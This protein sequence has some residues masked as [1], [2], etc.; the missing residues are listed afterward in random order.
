LKGGKDSGGKNTWSRVLKERKGLL[1]G[2]AHTTKP[3]KGGGSSSGEGS[4][5][6]S[7]KGLRAQAN[8]CAV[9]AEEKGNLGGGKGAGDHYYQF[10]KETGK[11]STEHE[12]RG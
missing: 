3:P 7:K 4:I 5:R 8:N 9:S 11:K 10:V 6:P 12:T 2:K 1:L